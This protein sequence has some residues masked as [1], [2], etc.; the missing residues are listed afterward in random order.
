[1]TYHIYCECE[2][3]VENNKYL[4]TDLSVDVVVTSNIGDV[5]N[6]EYCMVI[7]A[8]AII[9]AYQLD[10]MLSV[11]A[12]AYNYPIY[13]LREK[14]NTHKYKFEMVHTRFSDGNVVHDVDESI[15][16]CQQ[17]RYG[18]QVHLQTSNRC[19]KTCKWCPPYHRKP[20]MTDYMSDE[21]LFHVFDLMEDYGIADIKSVQVSRISES[22]RNLDYLYRVSAMVKKRFPTVQISVV[23]NGDGLRHN[24]PELIDEMTQHVDMLM[25]NDYDEEDGPGSMKNL[26]QQ[27][28]DS[29]GGDLHQKDVRVEPMCWDLERR[30]VVDWDGQLFACCRT[31]AIAPNQ[32]QYRLGDILECKSWEDVEVLRKGFKL[33]PDCSTCVDSMQQNLK[34]WDPYRGAHFSQVDHSVKLPR[35]DLAIPKK[36]APTHAEPAFVPDV[37]GVHGARVDIFDPMMIDVK[38]I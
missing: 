11:P 24:P 13:S 38:N 19:T 17:R 4:E 2:T 18:L 25:V 9:D 8:G 1:M 5:P 7:P 29:R 6:P 28:G 31:T 35:L 20:L 23:S 27:F 22:T 3:T 10:K 16:L 32:A 21:L 33:L 30:F 37:T 15:M 14:G 34:R 12:N 26:L 36:L